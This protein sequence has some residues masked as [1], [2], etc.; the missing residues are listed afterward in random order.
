MRKNRKKQDKNRKNL[1]QKQNRNTEK[2]THSPGNIHEVQRQL[3][4]EEGAERSE[5][6]GQGGPVG[7]AVDLGGSSTHRYIEFI[8]SAGLNYIMFA[9]N[10][11]QTYYI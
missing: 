7:L 5:L 8:D 10:S 3:S 4:R 11:V 2:T 1:E 6:R 9:H